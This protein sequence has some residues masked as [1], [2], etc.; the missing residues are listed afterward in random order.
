VTP[1]DETRPRL[2]LDA[3]EAELNEI[4]AALTELDGEPETAPTS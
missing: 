3:V 4:E 2:D 1:P